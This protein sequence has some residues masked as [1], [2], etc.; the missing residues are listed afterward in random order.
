MSLVFAP[1]LGATLR[2][3][4]YG[5]QALLMS[6]A[7]GLQRASNCDFNEQNDFARLFERSSSLPMPIRGL[8]GEYRQR[9][10]FRRKPT[11]VADSL[12]VVFKSDL[13][14]TDETHL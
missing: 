8:V 12:S 5:K 4:M 1:C 6:T 3:T 7:K 13:A 11:N 10:N 14:E 2:L 9:T